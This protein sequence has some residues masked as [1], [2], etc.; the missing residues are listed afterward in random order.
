[1]NSRKA[2]AFSLLLALITTRIYFCKFYTNHHFL[3]KYFEVNDAIPPDTLL[4]FISRVSNPMT[5]YKGSGLM[6][7]VSERNLLLTW[8]NR[9]SGGC[10]Q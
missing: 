6:G 1:M 5:K 3:Q 4:P 2:T 9:A 7:A 8:K 10:A